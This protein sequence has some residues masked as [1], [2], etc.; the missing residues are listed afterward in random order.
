LIIHPDDRRF[1]LAGG[2]ALFDRMI[3]MFYV[4]L[5]RPKTLDRAA[6]LLKYVAAAASWYGCEITSSTR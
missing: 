4:K 2:R 5:S 3:Q 6:V 1:V